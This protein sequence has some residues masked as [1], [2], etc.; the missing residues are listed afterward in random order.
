MRGMPDYFLIY[1]DVC[2]DG[3]LMFRVWEV[4][5][6]RHRKAIRAIVDAALEE[7]AKEAEQSGDVRQAAGAIRR[8]KF[9][10]YPRAA[11]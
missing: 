5:E 2:V 11:E 8:R 7:A 9:S 6:K 4:W 3:G 10:Y 1:D